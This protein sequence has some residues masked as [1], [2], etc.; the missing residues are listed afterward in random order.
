MG[1]R[2][3]QVR[4]VF[5][6]LVF[7]L[8]RRISMSIDFKEGETRCARILSF[9]LGNCASLSLSL[10]LCSSHSLTHSFFLFHSFSLSRCEQ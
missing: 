2:G 9:F 5:L 8:T 1:E 7:F 3:R 4:F 6:S 10:L